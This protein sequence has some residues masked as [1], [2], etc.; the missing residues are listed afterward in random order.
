M[1]E[2]I[3]LRGTLNRQLYDFCIKVQL[4]RN[5]TGQRGN[6]AKIS[7]RMLKQAIEHLKHNLNLDT[8][9]VQSI[10]SIEATWIEALATLKEVQAQEFSKYAGDE[11]FRFLA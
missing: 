10:T 9:P 4:S 3:A 7:D 5:D 11:Y 8:Q 1:Y 2:E 6:L